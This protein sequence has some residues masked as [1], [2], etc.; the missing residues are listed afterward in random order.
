M[1][2]C[3]AAMAVAFFFANRSSRD[4]S[5]TTAPGTSRRL[6][7]KARPNLMLARRRPGLRGC[8]STDLMKRGL[9]EDEV[10]APASQSSQS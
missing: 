10:V 8:S 9:P 5:R 1:K 7:Q 6:P 2:E 3:L 4:R